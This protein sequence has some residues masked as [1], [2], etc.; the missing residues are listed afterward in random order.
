MRGLCKSIS[1][2]VSDKTIDTGLH[3]Y[4]DASCVCLMTDGLCFQNRNLL[5]P[6]PFIDRCFVR[7]CSFEWEGNGRPKYE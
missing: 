6:I 2:L 7:E 5:I 1:Q 4:Y 3:I